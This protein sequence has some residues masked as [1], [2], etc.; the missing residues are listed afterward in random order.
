MI[1]RQ[2]A[3]EPSSWHGWELLHSP[4]PDWTDPGL[5]SRA[6]EPVPQPLLPPEPFFLLDASRRL[7]PQEAAREAIHGMLHYIKV[8]EAGEGY[9]LLDF[10]VEPPRLLSREE[11]VQRVLDRCGTETLNKRT[12]EQLR[13]WCRNYFR[14]YPG[15]GEDMWMVEPSFAV[16]W[17]GEIESVPYEACVRSGLADGDGLVD[18]PALFRHPARSSPLLL[19]RQGHKY[20]L[21]LAE[22]FFAQYETEAPDGKTIQK[23]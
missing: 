19:I 17:N 23:G 13:I 20:R 14:R 11:I 15:L 8:N 21:Q 2:V 7:T 10:R 18:L 4:D 1:I 5:A 12:E 22:A 6:V 9:Q 16:R 3:E